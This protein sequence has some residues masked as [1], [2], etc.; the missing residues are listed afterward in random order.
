SPT[1]PRRATP[2][3]S[4]GLSPTPHRSRWQRG[5]PIQ[6]PTLGPPLGERERA[7]DGAAARRPGGVRSQVLLVNLRRTAGPHTGKSMAWSVQEWRWIAPESA[8]LG[9]R[10]NAT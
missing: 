8:F 10:D 5:R 3:W 2:G 7:A 1:R 9:R 6:D 4:P